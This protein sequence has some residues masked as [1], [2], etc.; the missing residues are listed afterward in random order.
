MGER[1]SILC[2]KERE[3]EQPTVWDKKDVCSCCIS[4]Y[5]RRDKK[6]VSALERKRERE[7]V[8]VWVCVGMCVCCKCL[9][10]KE[11]ERGSKRG[12]D[13][14]WRLIDFVIH[15]LKEIDFFRTAT[16]FTEDRLDRFV[17]CIKLLLC[18]KTHRLSDEEVGVSVEGV[19]ANG[20]FR[21]VIHTC[22]RRWSLGS[23]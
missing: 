4:N 11:R 3:R 20:F 13:E 21:I 10:E 5:E 16:N 6:I 18:P 12:F 7:G 19:T 8:S 2:E 23:P 22:I 1:C 15:Q 14:A 9:W 17:E